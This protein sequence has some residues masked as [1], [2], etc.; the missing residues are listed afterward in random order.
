MIEVLDRLLDDLTGLNNRLVLVHCSGA[1]GKTALLTQ[2]SARKDLPI[3]NV[4]LEL[5]RNLLT[6]PKTQRRLS[7]PNLFN[8]IAREFSNDSLLIVD[9]IEILFDQHL[10]LNPLDLLRRQAQLRRLVAAWPGDI[11]NG[12]VSYATK[13]HPEYQNYALEGL[14]PFKIH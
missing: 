13:G 8:Q 1:A 5:G 12:R 11:Q 3:F 7:T 10:A 6:V 4:G 14:V 2:L 9:N